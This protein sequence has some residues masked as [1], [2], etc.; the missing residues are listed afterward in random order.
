[1]RSFDYECFWTVSVPS[2]FQWRHESVVIY[3]DDV[4][5][6]FDLL[7]SG[8]TPDPLQTCVS[9]MICVACG[10]PIA[11]FLAASVARSRSL[12]GFFESHKHR[13]HSGALLRF[14]IL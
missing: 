14:I 10:V 1:M 5:I 13:R 3:V 4:L 7:L 11:H 6:H 12:H 8:V 2:S 9:M